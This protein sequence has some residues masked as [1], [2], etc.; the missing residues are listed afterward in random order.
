MTGIGDEAARA[1]E[2]RIR[3]IEAATGV[4][5]I[6]A[7]VPRADDYVE[8]HWRAF[9]LG[10]AAAALAAVAVDLGRPDWP[11]SGAL[12][13]QA[14]V[15]LGAGALAGTLARFVPALRRLLIGPLRG[16]HEARQCAEAM[17]LE[18][19]LFATPSRTA[20]LILVAELERA[21]VVLP[22]TGHRSRIAEEA[23]GGVVGAMLPP[24]RAGQ[25]ARAF[26]AGLAALEALLLAHGHRPGAG[27]TGIDD[28]LVRGEAP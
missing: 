15:I 26:D 18:R 25:A 24:L 14:L 16:Q 17:F 4:Q 20:V 19:E 22:D 28:A 13:A 8:A 1:I 5:V 3:A 10:T 12:L 7:V 23:W 6:A 11:A 21:V 2:Q 9:A 27:G